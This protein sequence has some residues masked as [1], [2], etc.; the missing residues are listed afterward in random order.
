MEMA[1]DLLLLTFD[2]RTSTMAG[3]KTQA[4]AVCLSARPSRRQAG[5]GSTLLGLKNV[6]GRLQNFC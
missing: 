2:Q 4:C 6:G 3:E 1:Y 5:A